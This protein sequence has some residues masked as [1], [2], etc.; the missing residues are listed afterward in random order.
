LTPDQQRILESVMSEELAR[1]GYSIEAP[2]P[3]DIRSYSPPRAA[4]GAVTPGNRSRYGAK[5]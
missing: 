5:C 4:D 1:Q 2:L 3:A